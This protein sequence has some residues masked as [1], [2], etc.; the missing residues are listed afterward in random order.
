[1]FFAF[2]ELKQ[3]EPP[4]I[5]SQVFAISHT[6][7]MILAR[8][9][10]R[11]I[12][13]SAYIKN[14]ISKNFK[15]FIHLKDSILVFPKSEDRVKRQFFMSCLL[16]NL[17]K[18][19]AEKINVDFNPNVPFFVEF[20]NSKEGSL[21]PKV[22]VKCHRDSVFFRFSDETRRVVEFLRTTLFGMKID[23][24]YHEKVAKVK[25][26][27]IEEYGVIRKLLAKKIKFSD[28]LHLKFTYNEEELIRLNSYAKNGKKRFFG[29]CFF[30]NQEDRYLAELNSKVGDSFES[31]RQKYL[32]LVKI[33]HP[34][35]VYGKDEDTIRRY[36][37]KFRRIQDAFENLKKLR[38]EMAS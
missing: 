21:V 23:V 32:E 38:Y 31:I 19:R 8:V 3:L 17:N 25:V 2:L 10:G 28:S 33:Y 37:L 36:T 27:N 13:F 7:N 12:A 26:K 16:N 11:D 15:F 34:D 30:D 14:Y 22:I 9:D 20:A 29:D 4:V 24:D 35:R 5:A 6:E 1:M 18:N